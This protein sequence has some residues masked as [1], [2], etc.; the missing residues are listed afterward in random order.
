[1][2]SQISQA[3]EDKYCIS[4]PICGIYSLKMN[5]RNVKQVLWGVGR[6]HRMRA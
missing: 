2:L 1:M 5:D 3:W 4:F 6:V